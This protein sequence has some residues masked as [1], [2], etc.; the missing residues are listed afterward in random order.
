MS[1]SEEEF[2]EFIDEQFKN[3]NKV[4]EDIVDNAIK[5][6]REK[7]EN[8]RCEADFMDIF[9]KLFSNKVSNAV[10]GPFARPDRKPHLN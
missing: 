3:F 8:P 5:F 10:T 7:C 4:A 6:H 2:N 9:M 1:F